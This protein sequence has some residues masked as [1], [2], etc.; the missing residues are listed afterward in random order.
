MSA[1]SSR[2]SRPAD[3]DIATAKIKLARAMGILIRTHP[4]HGHIASSW[5]ARPDVSVQTMGVSWA[6]GG[7]QLVWNPDFVNG[8]SDMEIAGVLLHEVHHVVFRH[9]FLF[10]EHIDPPPDF[11]AYAALVAEELCVNEFVTLP[12][13]GSPFRLE[14]FVRQNPKCGLEPYESTRVRYRKLYDAARAKRHHSEREKLTRTIQEHLKELLAG[15]ADSHAGWGSFLDGGATAQLAVAVATA[16]A[17][18]RHGSALS[19]ELKN[20]I[21]RAH[22]LAGTTAGGTLEALA[23]T[24]RS[25]LS[26]QH[27]LRRLL[28]VDHEAE[29]TFLRPPR[30]FPDMA[31][32]LPGSRRIEK[33]L[34]ILAAIDTSASMSAATLDEIAAELR[35]MAQ[36]Y[37]VSVVEF[38]CAIQRRYRLQRAGHQH[39]GRVAVAAASSDPLKAMQGRGGTSF[40]PVFD[41]KT[42]AWAADGAELSGVVVFTDGFGPAPDKPPHPPVIWILM[43]GVPFGITTNG[44]GN[45]GAIGGVRRPASWGTVVNAAAE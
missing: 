6:C 42:L 8:I 5:R 7:V 22:K 45:G 36:S 23:G 21:Q 40:F 37:D 1:A 25:R 15:Q 11:D 27:I 41:P 19:A 4:F 2:R 34:R 17:M 13:P 14:E 16:Q 39:P 32:V 38:D 33:Q 24:A 18:A 20:L 35:V 43:G 29:P 31:G 9:M 28:S 26:W 3:R 12:M 30:R 44:G 10:P